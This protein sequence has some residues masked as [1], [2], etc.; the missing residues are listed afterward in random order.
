MQ[1]LLYLNK[2][3]EFLPVFAELQL[4]PYHLRALEYMTILFP[5]AATKGHIFLQ[6]LDPNILSSL[7]P[8]WFCFPFTAIHSLLLG[9]LHI[10]DCLFLSLPFPKCYSSQGCDHLPQVC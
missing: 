2:V 4:V 1:T 6:S 10:R 3:H 9:S 7:M 5:L 8:Q